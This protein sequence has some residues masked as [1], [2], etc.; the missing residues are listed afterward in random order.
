[1]DNKLVYAVLVFLFN[2]IGI[3]SFMN[4]NTEK[5]IY[6]I[7]S[8]VITF[9]ILGIVNAIKGILLAIKIYQMSDEEFAAADKSAL[10]DVIVLLYKG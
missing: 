4:G 6:T 7:I 10:E 1:M 3:T 5:G 8:D 2:A 9:G